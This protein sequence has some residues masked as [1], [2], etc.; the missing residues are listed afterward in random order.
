MT[1]NELKKIVIKLIRYLNNN[2][3]T[4][5]ECGDILIATGKYISEV[6]HEKSKE[7]NV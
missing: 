2:H 3:Y 5:K 1:R 4:Q 7:N 6:R